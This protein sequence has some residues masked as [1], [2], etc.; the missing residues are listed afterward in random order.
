MS[1]STSHVLAA[2]WVLPVTTPPLRDG[3]VAVEGERIAWVG[4]R[5]DLPSRF[6]QSPIRAFPRGVLLPG[7]VNAHAHLN[8][9]A[10]LGMVPGSADRFADWLRLV[11]RLQSAWP[12]E[13]IRQSIV[14]GLDLLITTGTTTVA[15]VST[16]PPLDPFIQ[17]PMRT[18][19]FHE[20]I[21]FQDA[22]AEER[23]GQA[24]AWLEQAG[25]TIETTGA[26]HV[27]LGIA[28]HAPYTVSPRLFRGMAALAR[29]RDLPLSV[30]LAETR[31]EELFLSR[32]E[33]DLPG[34]LRERG[35]W[36]ES[37]QPPRVSPVQYAAELGLLE[38]P[39]LAVHCNYLSDEDLQL[40]R[41]GRLTPV[42]C[43]GSHRFFGHPDHPAPRLLHAGVP[44][45][46]G[47]DSLASNAGLNM[48]R[49]VR[50]AA[51]AFPEVAPEIWLEA[52]TL[53]GARALGLAG[54]TGS[55]EAGKAADLQVLDGLPEEA[56][57]PL[58]A[59]LKEPLRQR[60]VMAR[61]T[62][63][64]VATVRSRSTGEGV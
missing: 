34:L 37:W 45:A 28:P 4:P 11:I 51:E 49:E 55:L 20:V 32:G 58:T 25:E 17:H 47:T 38:V 42:W 40:L 7:W 18:V 22:V 12:P 13:I 1:A 52:A 33:G 60:L 61:G 59:V 14:A 15:Q 24:E 43:P 53:A 56:V 44:L 64:R 19:L 41:G 27:T 35:V 31:A 36:D 26:D 63:V 16:L 3:V 21:G 62:A 29:E 23:L 10:A 48:L 9:T 6:L 46:L 5:R 8:L 39:G 50:L 30:H 54:E 2:D 57:D